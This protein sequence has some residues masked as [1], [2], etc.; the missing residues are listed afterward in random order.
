MRFLF[1]KLR[2]IGD[3]L[4]L[5][6]TIVATKRK[7]PDSE[8]WVL[9]RN[10]CDSILNGCPEIDRV[11]CTANPDSAHRRHGDILSD[12]KLATILRMTSFD[13]VFELTD[14][15]RARFFAIA[16]RTKNRCTNEHRTLKW[17]WRPL[18][19]RICTIKRHSHHQVI[20][21]YT[22]PRQVLELPPD[23]PNL[24]FEAKKTLALGLPVKSRAFAIFHCHTRWERKSWPMERWEQLV[25]SVLDFTPAVVISCGPGPQEIASTRALA[26]KFPGKVFSTEGRASWT[27]LA[28]LLH[29]ASYFVGVD[30]AAMH[31]AAAAGCPTVCLFGPSPA[32]EYHP[33]QVKHWMIRPQDWLEDTTLKKIPQNDL[34][35]EIPLW[36][37][38][39]ACKAASEFTDPT[40]RHQS[41]EPPKRVRMRGRVF[42]LLNH[43]PL[44]ES[45]HAL[46][47]MRHVISLA[48]NAPE[49]WGVTLV[50][51][52]FSRESDILKAHG[53][54]SVPNLQF[55]GLPSLRRVA[56]GCPLHIN[57]VFH[58]AALAYLQPSIHSG[59]IVSTASF[60]EMF[61]F[62]APRLAKLRRRPRLAY[63]VHQLESLTLDHAHAKCI[64]EFEALS[65]ADDLITTCLPLHE[66]LS[67]KFPLVRLANLGLAATYAPVPS[68]H[69]N[70]STL[71]IGYFGSISDEQGIPWIVKNW[72][73][74]RSASSGEHELH[75]YGRARRGA[76]SLTGSIEN[77]VYIH[78]QVPSQNVPLAC[79][80]LDALVIPSLN[81]AHR[82]SIAFTKAYDYA[83]LSLPIVAADLPTIREV[84]EPEKH[85]LYFAPGDATGL[86][87]AIQ[88]LSQ[89]FHIREMLSTNLK[90]RASLLSWDNRALRWWEVFTK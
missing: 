66:L 35:R 89:N 88:R 7:F 44:H 73:S 87:S 68:N 69:N 80:H 30:T 76:A 59:D 78:D 24:R 32:F 60:P 10:S 65:F 38:L 67:E 22:S 62:L 33:W 41:T 19:H 45:A 1:I 11:L 15:D 75:V 51:A 50:H 56:G 37:V 86:A 70:S 83:G 57:A 63:E 27:Q 49:G 71:R 53:Y 21:D 20:R 26:A 4:L 28:E 16:A 85:A 23:P 17:F 58:L 13:Y 31:L 18:F 6:P 72:H 64:R 54:K 42:F 74:V 82:A 55:R 52:S 34:M 61:R 29:E 12:L 36:R 2:H 40:S 81:I 5:T 25:R 46:Y 9:V 47:C 14:N 8:I 84:L 77:G 39:D 48:R 90:D 3:S 43:H 79:H